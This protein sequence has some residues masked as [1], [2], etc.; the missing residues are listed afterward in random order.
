MNRRKK[1]NDSTVPQ[2]THIE[3]RTHRVVHNAPSI[4]PPSVEGVLDVLRVVRVEPGPALFGRAR[5]DAG[6]VEHAVGDGGVD[7]EAVVLA[8]RRAD[9]ADALGV[10][11]PRAL[12]GAEGRAVH[13]ARRPEELVHLA[14]VDLGVVRVDEAGLL[15]VFEADDLGAGGEDLAD[16]RDD[17]QD[18]LDRDPALDGGDDLGARRRSVGGPRLL[19]QEDARLVRDLADRLGRQLD[20]LA[21]RR[22]DHRVDDADLA[23]RARRLVDPAVARRRDVDPRHAVDHR[24]LAVGDPHRRLRRERPVVVEL[25]RR[26]L[27]LARHRAPLG[28]RD[29]R[30]APRDLLGLDRPR[31]HGRRHRRVVLAL[32]V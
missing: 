24:L 18:A 9:D 13:E 3:R 14:V 27:L 10:G 20:A 26:R 5:R 19:G 2:H 30:E 1:K 32:A 4:K 16:A 8:T 25:R 7:E 15:D 12:D 22:A 29:D 6:D 23:E 11:A 31:R 21:D 17:G 28:R